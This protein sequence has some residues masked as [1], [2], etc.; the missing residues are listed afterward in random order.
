MSD[1]PSILTATERVFIVAPHPDDETLGCGGLIA[2]TVDRGG[3]VFTLFVTDGGAS[4]P[5]SSAWSRR[6]LVS[7]R[8]KEAEEALAI[9][10]AAD[11]PRAFLRLRDTEIPKPDSPQWQPLVSS[12]IKL[13]VEFDPDLV[14]LPWRRDPH[15]DHRD[16]HALVTSA[17]DL[18]G[19]PAQC[20]EYAIWLD[21][22]GAEEDFPVVGE[23]ERIEFP[24]GPKQSLKEAALQAHA[25]QLGAIDKDAPGG[26]LLKPETV[27]RLITPVETYFTPCA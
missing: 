17:L 11:Q 25:T 9:L 2:A 10:G 26:F 22:L 23:V 27:A 4:H 3:S 12:V 16:A 8:Q 19:S 21:E 15:C 7:E 5:E 20:I 6:R 24:I 1:I 13:L 14:V 18:A